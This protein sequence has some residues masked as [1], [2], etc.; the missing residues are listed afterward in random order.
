[1]K[2]ISKKNDNEKINQEI[3]IKNTFVGRD[4]IINEF[5][6]DYFIHAE[7]EDEW[8][9]SVTNYYGIPGIGKSKVL[10]KIYDLHRERGYKSIFCT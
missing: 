8:S 3:K 9:L 7:N 1:M 10:F 6:N 2:K 4:D 5:F